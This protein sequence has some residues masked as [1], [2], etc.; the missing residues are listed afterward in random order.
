MVS[1]GGSSS[2]NRGWVEPTG[3]TQLAAQPSPGYV[4]FLPSGGGVASGITPAIEAQINAQ[5]AAQQQAI[6]QM[7]AQQQAQQAAASRAA[8]A[9]QV[10]QRQAPAPANYSQAA[11]NWRQY[12]AQHP[13]SG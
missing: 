1:S 7:Y 12:K 10:A 3:Q 5:Q 6:A 13:G 4:N 8:L 9:S 2:Y 11:W